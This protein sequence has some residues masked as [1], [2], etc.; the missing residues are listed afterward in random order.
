M[1]VIL[2]MK[3]ICSTVISISSATTESLTTGLA[4]DGSVWEFDTRGGLWVPYTMEVD[5]EVYKGSVTTD[6]E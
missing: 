2:K 4:E 3:Q 1:K 5:Y 6:N